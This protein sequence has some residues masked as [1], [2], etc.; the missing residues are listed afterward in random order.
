MIIIWGPID[1]TNIASIS[2]VSTPGL[3]NWVPN[4][5]ISINWVREKIYKLK[6]I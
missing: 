2:P 5:L 1:S 3:V 4:D 6:Y